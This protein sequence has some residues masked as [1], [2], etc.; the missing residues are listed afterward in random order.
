MW[1]SV[2]SNVP[3][4]VYL[5]GDPI[6]VTPLVHPIAASGAHR[7]VLRHTLLGPRAFP[8]EIKAGETVRVVA[9]FNAKPPPDRSSPTKP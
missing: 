8:F 4:R 2:R 6:G 7:V 9:D 3:A 1:L 5:D